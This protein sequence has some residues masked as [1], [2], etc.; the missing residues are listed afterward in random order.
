MQEFTLVD[1]YSV[2][3]IVDRKGITKWSYEQSEYRE[4]LEDLEMLNSTTSVPRVKYEYTVR[5]LRAK[6]RWITK[7]GQRLQI[8]VE[9]SSQVEQPVIAH[10]KD[11]AIAAVAKQT[12]FIITNIQV[13]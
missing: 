13:I 4:A 5:Y 1:D 11:E 7:N 3:R 10:N 2:I 6:A 9:E 12:G 8:P